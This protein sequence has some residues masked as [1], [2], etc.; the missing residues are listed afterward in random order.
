MSGW[1]SVWAPLPLSAWLRR[2]TDPLPFPLGTPGWRL[3]EE[4]RDAV[5]HGVR[6]LG[7]GAGDQVLS[8]AYHAGPDVEAMLRA[9]MDVRFYA[10]GADLQPDADE[11]E[12]LIG[13]RTR[14][15]Y[16]VHYLGFP[17]DA[18]R[19]RAWCDERGLLLLEDAA[20][21]W[22]STR[23]GVPVGSAGDLALWSVYKMVPTPGG[24]VAICREPLPGG[25]RSAGFPAGTLAHMHGAWLGQR[26]G[27]LRR[28]RRDD[29]E[30]EFDAVTHTDLGDPDAPPART[31]RYLMRRLGS[32][33]V[34][35]VRR[36]NYGRLLEAL[37]EHVPSPFG[38]LPEGAC[39]WFFPVETE[40][41]RGMIEHLAAAGI[42]AMEFW[43]KGHPL[44]GDSE[45]PAA[46]RRRAATVALPVHHLLRAADVDRIAVATGA[47]YRRG[48]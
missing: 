40:N 35:A 4:G 16:L 46:T 3:Y 12:E 13:P 26:W 22:L 25:R 14:A 23:D 2:P 48:P 31:T 39:P 29:N 27:A 37:R 8:P 6:A 32:A 20:Q 28:L 41:R 5:W 18:P 38:R 19:W 33:S 36:E 45:F 15:L 42:G 21:A 17:Q 47:W 7:L 24:A 44:L 11:L 30:E 1:V 43:S 10:G 34:A 9:G